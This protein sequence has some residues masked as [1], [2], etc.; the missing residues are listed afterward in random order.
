[1]LRFFLVIKPKLL[2]FGGD[3]MNIKR[4]FNNNI[5]LAEDGTMIEKMLLGKG[6]GFGKKTHDIVEMDKVEKIFVLDSKQMMDKFI[7]LVGDI[8]VNHIE[9]TKRIVEKAEKDLNCKFDDSIYVGLTDHIN[10]TLCRYRQNDILKNALLWEIKKFYPNEFK[11]AL[12]TIS[13]MEYE[14]QIK[15]SEDEAGF[16]AMHYV[17]AQQNGEA[18]H[19]TIVATKVIQ[20]ILNIVK[21]HYKIDLDEVS[22]NYS[23]FITHIRFFLQRINRQYRDNNKED[24]LFMQVRVKY[25]DVYECANKIKIYLESKL[26][27]LLS[28]EEMLYFM[29]HI[30]R[31]TERE[32]D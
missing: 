30:K 31:L 22:I 17:N 27:I 2:W 5:V 14:E 19:E 23:R 28:D 4:I 1:M 10:Y 9:L 13:L 15:L 32:N 3:E 25:P 21:F 16:I 8:P 24:F 20:G 11:A 12:N 7:Q 6:I 18:V 29:L 26:K